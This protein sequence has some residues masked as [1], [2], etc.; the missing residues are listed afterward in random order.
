MKKIWILIRHICAIWKI[1]D[2]SFTSLK[3]EQDFRKWFMEMLN[4]DI[5]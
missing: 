3:E 4:E 1:N 2:D 5:W